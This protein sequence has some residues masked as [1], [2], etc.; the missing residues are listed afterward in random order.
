VI[1][2]H[3]LGHALD[4][5]LDDPYLRNRASDTEIRALFERPDVVRAVGQGAVDEL[6]SKLG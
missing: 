3:G 4:D 6:R 5:I 1:R 2:E